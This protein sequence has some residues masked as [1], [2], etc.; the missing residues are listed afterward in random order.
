MCHFVSVA[1]LKDICDIEESS[2]DFGSTA[3]V[4]S[5]ITRLPSSEHVAVKKFDRS[6]VSILKIFS[7]YDIMRWL[8]HQYVNYGQHTFYCFG[9]F[10]NISGVPHFVRLVRSDQTASIIMPYFKH[11]TFKVSS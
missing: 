4:V 7:E 9:D 6:S 10:R 8:I 1:E 3:T 11:N 5:A 2:P